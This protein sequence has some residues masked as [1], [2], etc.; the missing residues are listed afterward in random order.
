MFEIE[1]QKSK[2]VDLQY[3]LQCSAS[4]RKMMTMHT[5]K[6]KWKTSLFYLENELSQLLSQKNAVE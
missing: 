3:S 5:Q 1:L 2:C 4:P 6:E